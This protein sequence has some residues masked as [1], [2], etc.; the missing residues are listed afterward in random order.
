MDDPNNYDYVL[1]A[2]CRLALQKPMPF[3]VVFSVGGHLV[4]GNLATLPAFLQGTR[5]LFAETGTAHDWHYSQFFDQ[6]SEL[7]ANEPDDPDEENARPTH[8]C[9]SNV[10]I[11]SGHTSWATP[12]WSVRFNAITGWWFVPEPDAPP[13]PNAFANAVE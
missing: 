10:V 3:R 2:L 5:D 12:W 9:L 13:L 6:V 11:D 8:V 7:A 1:E 4:T